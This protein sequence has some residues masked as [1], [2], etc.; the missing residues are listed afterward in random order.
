MILTGTVERDLDQLLVPRPESRLVR[1]ATLLERDDRRA[2]IVR[3]YIVVYCVIEIEI[4]V[5][6]LKTEG[7]GEVAQ[8]KR[9]MIHAFI[10]RQGRRGQVIVI[11]IDGF[12]I[13]LAE[14]VAPVIQKRDG[15]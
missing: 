8:G 7:A 10:L 1:V 3:R 9:S 15:F 6:C 4:V 11:S 2:V 5:T 14:V 12:L 13:S